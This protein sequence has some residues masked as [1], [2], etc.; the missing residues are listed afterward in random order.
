MV[1]G[2][3]CH[4]V[5]QGESGPRAPES[6]AEDERS[7]WRSLVDDRHGYQNLILLCGVH[8]KVIDRD[9]AGHPVGRLVEM[10]QAHE[11][12]IDRRLSP[13]QRNENVIEVRYA[14][15]VD[16]W[17]RR[18]HVDQWDGQVSRVT[19]SGAMRKNVLEDLR[20]LNDWLLRRVW[21]R[22]LPR[23]EDALLN[24]RMVAE[25]LDA[26]VTRFSTERGG[27]VLIDRVHKELEGMRAGDEMRRFLERR[28][29]YYQDLAA[30]LA[31]ELTRAVNLVGER[32]REQL[33]PVYRLEEGYATIGL[34]F[35][36]G[37]AFGTLCPLY[38]PDAPDRPYPGLRGFVIERADR[39]Y[40]RGIGK[41]P[42]GAGL[43]GV[44]RD[45]EDASDV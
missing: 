3:E 9:V 10:K 8:H 7:R 5:A 15:I 34:G 1:A 17:A 4:I 25:D 6:L 21:P 37:L 29:E 16:E 33:W 35:D 45:F 30:D 42:A 19:V 36:E 31:I 43:P 26:V 14:A 41:P 20:T 38:P 23:L 13:G 28:S 39:D 18:A 27:D 22:T 40:S 12:E 2:E 24:F 44:G 32:V 11:Q